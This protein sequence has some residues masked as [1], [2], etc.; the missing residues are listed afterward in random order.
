VREV[1]RGAVTTVASK[2]ADLMETDLRV[3]SEDMTVAEAVV[4]LAE[5]HVYG[6]PVINA[7][8]QL[9]GVLSTSDVLEAAAEC[10]SGHERN[11][12]FER[13]LVGEIMTRSAR[14]IAPTAVATCAAEQMLQLGV[15]RLFV[16]HDGELVGVISQTDI[17]RAVART[18]L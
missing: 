1:S 14:T 6:L 11:Q 5:E 18:R 2:V 7:R 17:V 9:V 4:T 10:S 13:T 8:H 3:A 16:E 12:L 15:H